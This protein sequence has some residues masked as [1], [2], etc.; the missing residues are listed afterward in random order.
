MTI[1]EADPHHQE[2]A[3]K[4]RTYGFDELDFQEKA[5]LT[6]FGLVMLGAT[7]VEL[8]GQAIRKIQDHYKLIAGV[9]LTAAGIYYLIQ[10]S[11]DPHTP[12]PQ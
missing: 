1:A 8:T 12:D 10:Y 11:Q 2:P 9:S 7:G 6:A 3:P 5:L 4:P